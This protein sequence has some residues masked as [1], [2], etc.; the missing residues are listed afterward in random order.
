MNSYYRLGVDIYRP[1]RTLPL[2]FNMSSRHL[3]GFS[4]ECVFDGRLGTERDKMP[5]DLP[6]RTFDVECPCSPETPYLSK[7]L[8]DQEIDRAAFFALIG[9]WFFDMGDLDE[10]NVTPALIGLAGTGKSTIVTALKKAYPPEKVAFVGNSNFPLSAIVGCLSWIAPDVRD[11]AV[12]GRIQ[13]PGKMTVPI[14][15]DWPI[16]VDWRAPGIIVANEMPTDSRGLVIFDFRHLV[17]AQDGS[18]DRKLEAELPHIVVKAI[19]TY[20]DFLAKF[21]RRGPVWS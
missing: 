18:L 14:K 9:R 5:K 2:S 15:Y 6:I 10:W 21:G 19:L 20:H 8:A 12:I 16:V 3:F 4:D 13:T 7:I 11:N 1:S 17:T